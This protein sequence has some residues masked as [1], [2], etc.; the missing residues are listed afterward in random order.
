MSPINI[1]PF[2]T[3]A[4]MD[5]KR[6]NKVIQPWHT[7]GTNTATIKTLAQHLHGLTPLSSAEPPEAYILKLT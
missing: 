2:T 4:S 5:D 6:K 3:L 1:Q 7:M